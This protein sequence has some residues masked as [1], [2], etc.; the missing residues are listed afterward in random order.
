[1]LFVMTANQA[2]AKNLVL[3]I[4]NMASGSQ[5]YFAEKYGFNTS[6][7]SQMINNHTMGPGV[8]RKLE[9]IFGLPE[10]QMDRPFDDTEMDHPDIKLTEA[11]EEDLQTE[12]LDLWHY[13]PGWSKQKLVKD[14]KEAIAIK[15][16]ARDLELAAFNRRFNLKG[17]VPSARIKKALATTAR[18]ARQSTEKR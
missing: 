18:K 6:H 7:L 12:L 10:G 15:L 16:Q 4:R 8:A 3:L 1:M 2:R 9:K 5:S 13:L 14:L 11:E 17:T